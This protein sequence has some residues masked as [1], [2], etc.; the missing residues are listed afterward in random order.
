MKLPKTA[1]S[2]PA[3]KRVWISKASLA[4]IRLTVAKVSMIACGPAGTVVSM[5]AQRRQD[6]MVPFMWLPA[7]GRILVRSELS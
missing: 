7:Y 4:Q 5:A 1:T 3:P 6:S 2:S